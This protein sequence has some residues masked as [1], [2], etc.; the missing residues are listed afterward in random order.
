VRRIE[1]IVG[2]NNLGRLFRMLRTTLYF[3]L[4]TR[5]NSQNRPAVSQDPALLKRHHGHNATYFHPHRGNGDKVSERLARQ[6]AHYV[7]MHPAAGHM[8]GIPR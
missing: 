8:E 6:C 1:D 5:I 4:C 7:Q 3:L 2:A